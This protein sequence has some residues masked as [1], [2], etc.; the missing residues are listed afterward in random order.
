MA[1]NIDKDGKILDDFNKFCKDSNTF[2]SDR[3]ARI[4]D[5]ERIK[6][7][8]I[9][10]IEEEKSRKDLCKINVNYLRPYLNY[11]VNPYR[12]KPFGIVVSNR[13]P[14]ATDADVVQGLIR[15]IERKS[16]AKQPYTIAFDNTA[17]SGIGYFGITTDYSS[18]NDGFEQD[19]KIMPIVRSEMVIDD[20]YSTKID[21]SDATKRAL[22]DYMRKGQAIEEYGEDVFDDND[23]ASNPCFNT[24]WSAPEDSVCCITYYRLN[25]ERKSIYKGEDGASIEENALR[26]NAKIKQT[27]K[28]RTVVKTSCEVFKF[29]GKKVVYSTVLPISYIPIIAIRGNMRVINDKIDFVGI[30]YDAKPIIRTANYAI[31]EAFIR[32]A[33]APRSLFTVDARSVANYKDIIK[34]DL[35]IKFLPYDSID[36][37]NANA[38]YNK[39]ELLQASVDVSDMLG[40]VEKCKQ[41]LSSVLGMSEAG[42][43]AGQKSNQTAAEVLTKQKSQ[44]LSNYQFGDNLAESLKV[45]GRIIIQLL[46]PIYDTSRMV[47]IASEDGYTMQEMDVPSLNIDPEDYGIDVDSGPMGATTKREELQKVL[48]TTEIMN[49][50]Q[51]SK[52]VST[53]I[54]MSEIEGAE[55]IAKMFEVVQ[56]S[57]P[58]ADALMQQADQTI[59]AQLEKISALSEQIAQQNIY[60]QQ[61]QGELASVK[62]DNSATIYKANLDYQKAIVVE[63][64][65]QEGAIDKEK[66]R[67]IVEAEKDLNKAREDYYKVLNSK[68]EFKPV[69]GATPKMNAIAGQQSDLTEV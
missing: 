27:A 26:A 16:N 30:A 1:E 36:P 7:G 57:N 4:K 6:A 8:Q 28:S 45:A 24:S 69:E 2:L 60:I 39:P 56:S 64:M 53:V 15:G 54:R 19:I 18:E 31:N 62:A 35:P 48:A 68:P 52:I 22:V 67:I 44:D 23:K 46:N 65:K 32:L 20:P 11:I 14:T 9:F 40:M 41:D 59:Q 51:K 43:L 58:E 42:I 33:K 63:A 38:Q 13:N 55:N 21:G 50:E 10:S 34:S 12:E 3:I 37:N 29:I 61:M 17:N 49:D 25:K 5:D 66:L 47:P